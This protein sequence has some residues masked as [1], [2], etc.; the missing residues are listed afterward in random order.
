[1]VRTENKMEALKNQANT[2]EMRMAD[3]LTKLKLD[4]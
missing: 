2:V 3:I 1:M 4:N